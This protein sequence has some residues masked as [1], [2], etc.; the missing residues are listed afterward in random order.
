MKQS[1][2]TLQ[3]MKTHIYA[4]A[5]TF[6]ICVATLCANAPCAGRWHEPQVPENGWE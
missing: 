1:K 4:Y 3:K 5:T 2:Y 6:L